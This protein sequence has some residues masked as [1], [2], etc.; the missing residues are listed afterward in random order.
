MATPPLEV[1]AVASVKLMGGDGA[2]WDEALGSSRFAGGLI[3][4]F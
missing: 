1:A 3:R 2:F 4:K